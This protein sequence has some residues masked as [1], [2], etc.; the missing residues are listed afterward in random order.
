MYDKRLEPV[1]VPRKQLSH[2]DTSVSC[3]PAFNNPALDDGRGE[4]RGRGGASR[5]GSSEIE[6]ECVSEFPFG[7]LT[8][9]FHPSWAIHDGLTSIRLF[10]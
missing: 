3:G 9:S 8:N 6:L 4:R 7:S 10:F 1:D 2:E 5:G